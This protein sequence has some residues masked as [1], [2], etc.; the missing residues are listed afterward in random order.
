MTAAVVLAAGRGT[1]MGALTAA[2]PKPLLPVGGRPLIEHI[3]R[4]VAA[5]GI[6]R[7]V[8]VIGY[9]GDAIEQALGTGE[10]LGLQ[11]TYCRQADTDGT[12]HAL[13]L[14]EPLV[15]SED[16]LV[17][18]GDI[19]VPQPFYREFLDAFAR[20]P[21]DAQ[22]AVNEVEDPWRGAAVYVDDD[23]RV[24]RL[25][26]KPSPGTSTTRWNNAG[27]LLHTPP[28]FGYARRV[29]ASPRGEYELPQAVAQM[30]RDG[31]VVRA[32]PVRGA[33]CDVG[34]PEDLAA[35]NRVVG[36]VGEP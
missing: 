7:A 13:L 11:L 1:R 16:C 36:A 18:W 5:A 6:R 14:T 29:A 30:V 33:W 19:L 25:E 20:A 35:A 28:A 2:T 9:L 4:G 17:S 34:T 32:V 10:R 8:V 26:E 22:L 24:V 31:C 21:C 15:S 27:I 3:L 12:A 23:W